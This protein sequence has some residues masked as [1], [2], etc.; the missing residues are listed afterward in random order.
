MDL[1]MINLG[2]NRDIAVG[3]WVDIWGFNSDLKSLSDQLNTISY[4]LLANISS[5]VTK[6]YL[7]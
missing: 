5:R 7:E 6:N 3:D 4:S 2:Q 1:L